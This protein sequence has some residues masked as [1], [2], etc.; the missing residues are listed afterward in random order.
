M[1]NEVLEQ[2]RTEY[3]SKSLD[4]STI[5]KDPILQFEAW[6]HEAIESQLPEPNAMTLAT[7]GIDYKPSARMVLL[8]RIESQHFFFFTNYYSRKGKELLWNPY[9]ALLF[10]WNELHRQVRIEGRVEKITSEQSDSYFHSRP[11]G[12]QLGA[13]AS[14]QSEVIESRE[15]LEEKFKAVANQLENFEIPRPAHWGGYKVIPSSIEFWQGRANRMHDRILFTL[16]DKNNW[17]IERLAP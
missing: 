6:F 2:L 11:K 9:A 10:F 13:I 7:A 8:K 12:S 4:E 16:I 14:P 1:K 5:M 15:T 17:A 3:S